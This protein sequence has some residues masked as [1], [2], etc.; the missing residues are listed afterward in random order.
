MDQ[1]LNADETMDQARKVQVE[2][3]KK[4]RELQVTIY[5]GQAKNEV[6]KYAFI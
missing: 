5:E 2:I 4:P 6:I 3:T 1:N